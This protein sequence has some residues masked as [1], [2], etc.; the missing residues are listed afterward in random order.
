MCP[1]CLIDSQPVSEELPPSLQQY[2]IKVEEIPVLEIQVHPQVKEE[3]VDQIIVT[4]METE[5]SND[6]DAKREINHLKQQIDQPAVFA[7]VT[8]FRAELT[9]GD[10]QELHLIA[11]DA[12]VLTSMESSDTDTASDSEPDDPPELPEPLTAM[13]DPTL[14]Q[15][16]PVDIREK[17][18]EAYLKLKR[19]I[20]PDQC[21][22]LEAATKQQ[23]KSRDWH[24]H[25]AGRITSTTFYNACKGDH[26]DK[27]TLMKIMHYRDNDIQDPAVVWGREKK[28]IARQCYA[29]EIDNKHEN[30]TV[31][32]CGFVIRPDEPHLGASP[33]GKVLCACCGEG[34]LE[35]KCPYKYRKGLQGVAVSED[36]CLDQTF[37]LKKTHQYY[38]Q[39][40]LHM[41]VC[42]VQYCDFVVWT[43][44]EL[45]LNRI[46]RDEELLQKAL[47]KAKLCYVACILPELLTR[48]QDPALKP[49]VLPPEFGKGIE[50]V[51]CKHFFHYSCAQVKK[52]PQNWHCSQC[53][54]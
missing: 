27:T 33:D 12:A 19:N 38:H 21:E 24:T 52:R 9:D 25:R 50:C 34:V 53:R 42:D 31:S 40:Q 39:V 46:R 36:F 49:P 54:S 17:C 30:V 41:F 4:V 18:E 35:I 13:Y 43:T 2:D 51:K 1:L 20:H 45:V 11:P 14:R 44:Q 22:R 37:Q 23:A 6:A 47:P 26:L 16:T 29:E 48:S 28:E 7:A 8:P 3:P 15:H 32:L 5:M 10:I